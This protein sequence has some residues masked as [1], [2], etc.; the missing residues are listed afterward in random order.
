MAA[1]VAARRL[2]RRLRRRGVKV[3]GDRQATGA[4]TDLVE[5][6]VRLST[7]LEVGVRFDPWL[8]LTVAALMIEPEWTR[9]QRFSVEFR[10][11]DLPTPLGRLHIR[12][13]RPVAVSET[14]L[15]EP[16]LATVFGSANDLLP[17]LSDQPP[18]SVAVEGDGRAVALLR[19]WVERAQSG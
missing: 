12:D 19:R 17:A 8:A 3:S 16:P 1:A 4:L 14:S 7:L 13:G 9:G 6:P 10:E 15:L 18:A 5:R 11:P 2:R